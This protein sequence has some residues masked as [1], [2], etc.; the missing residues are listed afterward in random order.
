[1]SWLKGR[2]VSVWD[3]EQEKR[4]NSENHDSIRPSGVCSAKV[5]SNALR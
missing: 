4:K 5:R 3:L 2:S 1:M